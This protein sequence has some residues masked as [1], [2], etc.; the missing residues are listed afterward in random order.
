MKV[1]TKIVFFPFLIRVLSVRIPL[2][3]LHIGNELDIHDS[4]CSY[5]ITRKSNMHKYYHKDKDIML[6]FLF[7]STYLRQIILHFVNTIK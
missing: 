2:E 5:T 6:L 1:V 4:F 7:K 3:R